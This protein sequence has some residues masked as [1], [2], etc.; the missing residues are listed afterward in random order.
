VW[1]PRIGSVAC[2]FPEHERV[3]WTQKVWNTQA[4]YGL[5]YNSQICMVLQAT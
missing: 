5:G 1:R 3:E 4:L 2:V